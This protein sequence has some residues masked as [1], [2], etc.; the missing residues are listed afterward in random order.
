MTPLSAPIERLPNSNSFSGRS[1]FRVEASCVFSWLMVCY[2]LRAP[3]PLEILR[4]IGN[5]TLNRSF[6]FSN[7]VAD[8]WLLSFRSLSGPTKSVS[9]ITAAAVLPPWSLFPTSL[10]FPQFCCC[11]DSRRYLSVNQLLHQL[12]RGIKRSTISFHRE[13]L[14][15][16]PPAP[17]FKII[18]SFSLRPNLRQVFPNTAPFCMID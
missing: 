4:M 3:S 17:S 11:F 13:F 10:S 14:P 8:L 15:F 9:L 6:L 1:S 5:L 2:P 12:A 16:P 18:I 7:A